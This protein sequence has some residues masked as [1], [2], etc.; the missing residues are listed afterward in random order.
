M[1]EIVNSAGSSPFADLE[2]AALERRLFRGMCVSLMLAVTISLPFAPWRVTSGLVLGGAL[3]FFNH[4][5][6]RT[7]LKAVFGNTAR[8][9]AGR[10]RLNAARYVLRYFVIGLVI[11]TAYALDLVSIAATIAGLC[12]FAA[13][14]MIE[15]LMQL[16]FAIVYREEN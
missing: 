9:G 1:S 5:W 14:I 13:A 4:H 6:L 2:G 16:Y 10:P 11:A 12:S 3:S 7:S 8:A 15:A